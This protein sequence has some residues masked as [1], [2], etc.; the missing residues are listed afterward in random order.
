MPLGGDYVFIN[1]QWWRR[2][3]KNYLLVFYSHKI[4]FLFWLSTCTYCPNISFPLSCKIPNSENTLNMFDIS[5]KTFTQAK[6][7]YFF[8]VFEVS[9]LSNINWN[10]KY[11]GKHVQGW[12]YDEIS[13]NIFMCIFDP[14]GRNSLSDILHSCL[15]MKLLFSSF[16]FFTALVHPEARWGFLSFLF[17]LTHLFSVWPS[18]L[19]TFLWNSVWIRIF[20]GSDIYFLWSRHCICCSSM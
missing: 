19:N 20:R 3:K 15:R 17:F 12:V 6:N 10:T 5:F 18:S 9:W 14:C 13:C 16:P 2:K 4:V 8:V 7:I 11:L 1:P